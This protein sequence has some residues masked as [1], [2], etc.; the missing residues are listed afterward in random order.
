MA[1][2]GSLSRMVCHP[3]LR[4]PR[5]KSSGRLPGIPCPRWGLRGS[6]SRVAGERPNSRHIRHRVVVLGLRCGGCRH[7]IRHIRHSRQVPGPGL[8]KLV[9]GVAADGLGVLPPLLR[10]DPEGTE[11]LGQGA[12]TERP[13]MAPLGPG[14]L[15]RRSLRLSARRRRRSR[16][17]PR[18]TV[19]GA[20][21]ALRVGERAENTAPCREH[22]ASLND[23]RRSG[24]AR[25]R[26]M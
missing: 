23:G 24:R 16:R 1:A 15:R 3:R 18:A 25:E 14:P 11:E 22:G 4:L 19:L 20:H 2:P 26:P 17:P 10:G 8:V 13:T 7:A 21:R 5:R 6:R 12:G 9:A